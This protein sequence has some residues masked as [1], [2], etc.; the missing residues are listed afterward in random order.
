MEKKDILSKNYYLN[1]RKDAHRRTS[2]LKDKH[3]MFLLAIVSGLVV[4]LLFYLF[5][6][7]SHIYH[8]SIEGNYYLSDEDIISVSGINENAS[9]FL[10]I[11]F[12][13]NKKL[14]KDPFIKKAEVSYIENN[15]VVIKVVENKAL[16]YMYDNGSIVI[17]MED[18]SRV[19][20]TSDRQYLL[21]KL[22]LIEGYTDEQLQLI[23]K[24]FKQ[25]DKEVINE[26]SEIHRY[27]F[28]YDEN[29][30]EVIMRDGN[31]VFISWSGLGMLDDYY[32]IVSGLNIRDDNRC[33]FFDEVTDSGYVSNCPW[34]GGV[35]E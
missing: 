22:P 20:L 13:K 15:V 31:Y 17:L 24:G 5:S 19:P 32:S 18:D 21:A 2:F 14:E 7:A 25:I 3:Q 27:S 9:I 8:V 23:E 33:L 12:L 28:S 4:F 30:M 6:P 35:E 26:I 1:K 34:Q 29:M 16:A 11:P 10:N